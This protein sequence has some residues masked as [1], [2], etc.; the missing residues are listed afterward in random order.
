M[1]TRIPKRSLNEAIEA[2]LPALSG[3]KDAAVIGRL[4]S[5]LQTAVR[6]GTGSVEKELRTTF[7]IDIN[8][9]FIK[10]EITNIQNKELAFLDNP[11]LFIENEKRRL[12]SNIDF[13]TISPSEIKNLIKDLKELQEVKLAPAIRGAAGGSAFVPDPRGGL[14]PTFNVNVGGVSTAENIF[15]LE[16][17]LPT[18]QEKF[19]RAAA[20]AG[21]EAALPGELARSTAEAVGAVRKEGKRFVREELTPEVLQ[22]L[23]VR[24]L[25]PSGDLANE[26]ARVSGGVQSSIEQFES[27][28]QDADDLF[29]QN[30]GFRNALQLE[31]EAGET[32]AGRVAVERRKVLAESETKFLSD[33]AGLRNRFAFEKLTRRGQTALASERERLRRERDLSSASRRTGTFRN[34][35]TA[36]GTIGGALIGAPGG[37]AGVTAGATIGSRIGGVAGT[38]IGLATG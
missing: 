29:F 14:L 22:Q 37:P 12:T 26:L 19:D 5:L 11:Q 4:R 25:L 9:A 24:G 20:S 27:E 31:L 36:V 8:N 38:E 30:A 35:G 33:V 6:S 18:V 23:N 16:Q 3:S 13:D 10:S 7:G 32:I 28:L 17:L 21:L 15:D 1:A 2:L 34:I